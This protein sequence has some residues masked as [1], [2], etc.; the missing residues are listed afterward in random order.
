MKAPTVEVV[1]HRMAA[2]DA[3]SGDKDNAKAIERGM[4]ALAEEIDDLKDE[5]RRVGDAIGRRS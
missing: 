5:I 1:T 2:K 4:L 3:H